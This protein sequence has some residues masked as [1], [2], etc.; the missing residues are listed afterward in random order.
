MSSVGVRELKEHASEIVRRVREDG[1]TIDITYRGEIVATIVPK[2]RPSQQELDEFW[3]RQKRLI[4][5]IAAHLG[6]E[7]IDVVALLEEER[8]EFTPDEMLPPNWRPSE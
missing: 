6:D 8:R 2:E 5:D 4:R 3:K 7:P 1:E